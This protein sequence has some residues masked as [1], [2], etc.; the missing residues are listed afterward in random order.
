MPWSTLRET[1]HPPTCAEFQRSAPRQGCTLREKSRRKAQRDRLTK[2]CR[3]ALATCRISGQRA[4]KMQE[5][6]GCAIQSNLRHKVRPSEQQAIQN[7]GARTSGCLVMKLTIFSS[8]SSCRAASLLPC[9]S[10][11][12]SVTPNSLWFTIILMHCRTPVREA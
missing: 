12:L 2:P 10:N 4:L 5:L 11:S 3:S 6:M 1:H 7:G 9:S 8:R